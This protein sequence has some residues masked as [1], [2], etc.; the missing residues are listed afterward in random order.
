MTL[1]PPDRMHEPARGEP[2]D[3]R[4]LAK[5]K[6]YEIALIV[7]PPAPPPQPPAEPRV[8]LRFR[9]EGVE[10]V[11]TLAELAA[12]WADMR[13][14]WAYRRREQARRPHRH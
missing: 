2:P 9:R 3:V 8:R 10:A 12:L 6:G 1:S 7:P 5:R 11:L 13:R 14:L 4:F